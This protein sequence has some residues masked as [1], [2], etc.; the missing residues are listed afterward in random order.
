MQKD[1]EIQKRLDEAEYQYCD[2]C[3]HCRYTQIRT[4][5]NKD[6]WITEPG[7]WFR[8]SKLYCLL[9]RA[10]VGKR[11]ICKYYEM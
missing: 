2:R 10:W 11:N 8:D 1:P 6:E 3:L 7:V 4:R 9:L 5:D